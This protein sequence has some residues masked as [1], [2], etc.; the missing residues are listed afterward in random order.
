M[1]TAALQCRLLY[2]IVSEA[3]T[4]SRSKTVKEISL[5]FEAMLCVLYPFK[6]HFNIFLVL[7]IGF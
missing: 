2:S 6:K 3:N 5:Y 7:S 4:V 1:V